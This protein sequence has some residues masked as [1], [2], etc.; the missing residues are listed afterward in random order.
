MR[1]IRL[2]EVP[3]EERGEYSIKRLFTV[4]L[5]QN[6]ENV[7]FY[8]TTIPPHSVVKSHFHAKLDEILYFLTPGRVETESGMHYLEAGDIMILFAGEWHEIIA[9]SEEVNLIAVKLPNIVDDKVLV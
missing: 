4:S 2:N 9:E 6:P 5:T 8:Q 1:I 7:G 3:D